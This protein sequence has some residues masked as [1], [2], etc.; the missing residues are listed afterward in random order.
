MPAS[1][2]R[3]H[4]IRTAATLAA[5]AARAGPGRARRAVPRFLLLAVLLHA[6]PAF[7]GVPDGFVEIRE[8]IPGVEI[9]VRYF[10]K[11]NFVG[12]RVDG[13]Q[14]AKIYTTREAARAL[15]QV[16]AELAAFGLGLKIFDAYRPQRAVDHFVRWAEDTGDTKMKARYYPDVEKRHL[17][18]DG[19]IAAKSGH[20]RGSTVDLTLVSFGSGQPAELDMGT[21][22]DFFGPKSW[23][24]STAPGES[25]A[26]STSSRG[27]PRASSCR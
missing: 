18:R 1:V 20:S 23:P 9:D 17:F 4:F 27:R 7:G 11:D 8:V 15:A 21:R 26:S 19:Y 24:A 10:S 2:S 22:W 14:D 13:Y 12:E 5:A 6:V 16:Q 3:R 25:R